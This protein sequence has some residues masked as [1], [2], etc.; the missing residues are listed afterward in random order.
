M[1]EAYSDLNEKAGYVATCLAERVEGGKL[2]Q[3][4]VY[5]FTDGGSVAEFYD[6]TLPSMHGPGP[7]TFEAMARKKLRAGAVTTDPWEAMCGPD[8]LSKESYGFY[9]FGPWEVVAIMW[10]DELSVSDSAAV[11]P[12]KPEPVPQVYVDFG[13]AL[14]YTKE[15]DWLAVDMATAEMIAPKS[16]SKLTPLKM[17]HYP[18]AKADLYKGGK[19]QWPSLKHVAKG[20]GGKW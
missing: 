7:T 6:P 19:D 11:A 4:R 16:L 14:A 9:V 12:P 18:K 1:A 3:Y 17:K 15:P 5:C 13:K 10:V 20:K 8:K 2:V